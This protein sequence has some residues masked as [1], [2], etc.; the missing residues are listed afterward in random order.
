MVVAAKHMGGLRGNPRKRHSKANFAGS[1][2]SGA[3]M[4]V[5]D[6]LAGAYP[7]PRMKKERA[8]K[9]MQRPR[10]GLGGPPKR[11][12]A[13]TAALAMSALSELDP[14]NRGSTMYMRDRF[15]QSDERSRLRAEE[16]ARKARFG[17]ALENVGMP[18]MGG[19]SPEQ[20]SFL[21]GVKRD[22]VMDARD[23][24]NFNRGVYE[25]D[26]GHGFNVE[27]A[28]RSDFVTDRGFQ[29]WRD[30]AAFNQ[31]MN[32]E[33]LALRRQQIE[34]EQA[35]QQSANQSNPYNLTGK[36]ILDLQNDY[37]MLSGIQSKLEEYKAIVQREGLQAFRAGNPTAARLDALAADIRVM[38]KGER[39]YA[40]GVLAGPDMDLLEQIIPGG[41]GAMTKLQGP[42]VFFQGLRP[43]EDRISRAIGS[44]PE[45][46]RDQPMGAPMP[47]PSEGAGTTIY[48]GYT[49]PESGFTFMGGDPS[50]PESWVD[51]GGAVQRAESQST[52]QM[53]PNAR[54][55]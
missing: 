19:L 7:D 25:S 20:T 42:E 54:M 43:F 40:L 36:Q 26:R 13:R 47:M 6:S 31:T 9:E 28:N 33:G 34:A 22:G 12:W 27:R 50:S 10:G 3:D 49:D 18:G 4:A 14:A 48:P 16:E 15:D 11:N 53:F 23:E 8:Y 1:G 2:M 32:E 45:A 52:A 29:A 46:Y 24:R 17:K 44:I 38:A 37:S 21:Y 5:R 35:G 30:D 41:T 51:R 55:K 39:L